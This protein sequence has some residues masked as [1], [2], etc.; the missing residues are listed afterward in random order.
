MRGRADR[1][2]H[3][4]LAGGQGGGD[5]VWQGGGETVGEITVCHG[6]G[7]KN[8]RCHGRR[9]KVSPQVYILLE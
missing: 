7:E 8:D 5:E 9:S 4:L 1:D 6:P 2:C 3:C